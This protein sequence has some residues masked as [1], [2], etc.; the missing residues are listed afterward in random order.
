[1]KARVRALGLAAALGLATAALSPSPPPCTSEGLARM[2][3][4]VA[5]GTVRPD[6][7]RWEPGGGF[8]WE[9][10]V[11]RRVLFLA[12]AT[13][14]GPRDLYRARVRIA[15]GGQPISVSGVRNLTRTPLGDDAGLD[16][17]GTH[18][19]F[20]TLAFGRIQGISVLDLDG[21]R[22]EDC[23]GDFWDSVLRSI[24]NFQMTD[25]FVGIGR[26]DIVLQVPAP[27]AGLLLSEDRLKID[28]GSRERDLA[29]AT[30]RRVVRALDGSQAY[31]A[32]VVPSRHPPKPFILWAVDTVRQEVGPG[33]IAWL[34]DQVF[35]ARDVLRRTAYSL[36]ASKG[37]RSLRA[38][39]APTLALD[40]SKVQNRQSNWPPTDV[41]SAWKQPEPGE[42][43]WTPVDLAFLRPALVPPGASGDL[44]PAYFYMTYTRPDPER[45]YAK[46]W[47]VAMD[48]RQLEL[49]MQAGF[50]DPE[51]LA[52]PAGEGRL[53]DDPKVLDRV[54]ATFNGA[55]KTEHGKYGM[56]VNRRVL[57]PPIPGGASVVIDQNHDVGMGSWPK[58]A[59]IS[60][61]LVAFRQNLDPLVEDG[62]D[63]PTGRRLWGWQIEGKSVL[64]ERTALCVTASR[65]LI[66]AW[67]EEID[68]PTLGQALRQVGC[69]YGIHLDMNPGHC[70]FVFTRVDDL[71]RQVFTVRRA[72]PK[73]SVP[74]D[75]YVRWSPKDFFY[76]LLRDPTPHDRTR[77]EYVPD[78]GL[79]P[80]P[81]WSPGIFHAQVRTGDLPIDLV[82]FEPGHVQW[83]L[84]A[85][86]REPTLVNAPPMR[87]DL[88]GE[89]THR[90]LGAI[91]LGHTTSAVS[92]GIAFDGVVSL[93]LRKGIA[94]LV[95]SPDGAPRLLTDDRLPT[96]GPHESAVQLPILARQGEIT[97]EGRAQ[98]SLRLRGALC[99]TPGGRVL[100]ARARNDS[101]AAL[102]MVLL[103]A[104]CK[105]VAE[106][107][108]GSR[109]PAFFHR[110]GTDLPPTGDYETS[111]LYALA[112]PM[113]PHA[114]RWK[115]A[116]S[117]PSD[118]PTSYDLPPLRQRD[119]QP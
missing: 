104:G 105:D 69:S 55:F 9:A 12:A 110:A 62:S 97:A 24:T 30:D 31:A 10:L 22:P 102:V 58:S 32:R 37:E 98:G 93:P 109:H 95:I 38:T 70:G 33:P 27:R 85:G 36:T 17:I 2:L 66:Y 87:T 13:D 28:L 6:D 61:D 34:E 41:A 50:E 51:P 94:T 53:P 48:M 11:G 115:P 3:G 54:V 29:Y 14:G 75:R 111:V 52:G 43:H 118:K 90:V 76:V 100:M 116:G 72:V 63:N 18:A 21:I 25:S 114:Y 68:G 20:A 49:G 73:M 92:L 67:G 112:R 113:L 59:A 101:Y 82:T 91:G 106:L 79:Q 44:P 35:G 42:G 64:T 96:L 78:G 15:Y 4:R 19:A 65:N 81:A 46:V 84:R 40:S 80:P 23:A 57:L 103:R 39:S 77:A 26:T 45:P 89:D 117:G 8:L 108:R 7:V 16:L 119:A 107:D 56:M 5:G 99:T 71:R 83:V 47:F 60:P 74:A 86:T 88:T 1:M